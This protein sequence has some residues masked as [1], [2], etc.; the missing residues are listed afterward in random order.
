MLGHSCG[1]WETELDCPGLEG[2]WPPAGVWVRAA[3]K[4]LPP[5]CHL[6]NKRQT[7]H[8]ISHKHSHI[9][10]SKIEAR[11]AIPQNCPQELP[12][13]V[14]RDPQDRDLPYNSRR[15]PFKIRAL[16]HSAKHQLSE[17]SC[18]WNHSSCFSVPRTVLSAETHNW[19][20]RRE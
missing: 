6:L 20:K 14:R 1:N 13:E 2:A 4:P 3:V 7:W 15:P 19:P 18:S 16:V 17:K 11:G 12:R 9:L 5:R 10:S 8:W